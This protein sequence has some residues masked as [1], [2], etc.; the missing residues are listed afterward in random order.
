MA[1]LNQ[2]TDSYTY[3]SASITLRFMRIQKDGKFTSLFPEISNDGAR[4]ASSLLDTPIIIE[5]G[6][7][8]PGTNERTFRSQLWRH[9]RQAILL[10]SLANATPANYTP[11]CM[12]L[13]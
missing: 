2:S 8:A 4:S 11:A 6:K 10:S 1:G 5:H 13:M 9:G 3:N 7:A 12:L